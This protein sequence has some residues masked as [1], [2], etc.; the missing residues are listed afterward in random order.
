MVLTELMGL[1]GLY[2]LGKDTHQNRGKNYVPDRVNDPIYALTGVVDRGPSMAPRHNMGAGVQRQYVHPPHPEVHRY[3]AN[4][5]VVGSRDYAVRYKEQ[6]MAYR[7]LESHPLLNDM[8]SQPGNYE[9]NR[10]FI[11]FLGAKGAQR[12][13]E[14]LL[15]Q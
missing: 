2:F 15:R 10:Q 7:E 4:Q 14:L 5:N 6:Q 3:D 1:A 8:G 9:R 11:R 13:P 12:F